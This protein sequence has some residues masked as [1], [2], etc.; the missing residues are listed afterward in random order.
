MPVRFLAALLSLSL[1]GLAPAKAA[2]PGT[3]DWTGFYLGAYAGFNWGNLDI[4][5]DHL[6]T[7]GNFDENLWEAGVFGGYRR[8][9]SNRM[10]IGAELMVP[11]FLEKGTAEDEVFFPAPAFDP[12]VKYEAEG[13]WGVFAIAQVGRAFNRTLPFIEAGIGVVNA[14]GRTLNVDV[15]DLYDPGAKQS[16]TNTHFAFLVGAGIDHAVADHFVLGI[17]YNYMHLSN[18][19]YEMPWNAPPPNSFGASS[20]KVLATLTFKF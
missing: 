1:L 6:S 17:R 8:Q 2:E 7:T 12:P 4:S 13:N 9:L 16:D 3:F 11:F 10:V 5:E 14:T 20:H 15:N 19:N 18:E